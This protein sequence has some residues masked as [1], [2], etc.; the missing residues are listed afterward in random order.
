MPTSSITLNL[1][2]RTDY[3]RVIG[4]RVAMQNANAVLHDT[5]DGIEITFTAEDAKSLFSSMGNMIRQLT[6]VGNVLDM[7]DR[8]QA[9]TLNSR[10]GKA[11]KQVVR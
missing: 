3:S 6:V 8:Q 1:G 10:V 11:R 7:L 4:R 9:Q 5:R 2:P